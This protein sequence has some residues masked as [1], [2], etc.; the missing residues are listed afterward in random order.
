MSAHLGRYELGEKIAEGGMA[1]VYRA[2]QHGPSGF[3]RACA[4]KVLL[5]ESAEEPE[6]VKLLL[7]E[8]RIAAQLSHPNIC[9]ILELG[10]HGR[11]YFI[12]MEYLEGDSLALVFKRGLA[13][14][15]PL[16]PALAGL[17]VRD[18]AKALTHAHEKCDAQGGALGIIHRDVSPQNVLLTRDGHVKLLD[19]G[20]ARAANRIAKTNGMLLGKCAYMSPEQIRGEPLSPASDL[21]ALSVVLYELLSHRP[22]FAG[23][24]D[25][26]SMRAVLEQ[27]VEP[28][29]EEGARGE[30][31][32]VALAGLERDCR[33][34]IGTAREYARRLDEVL[35]AHPATEVDLAA[36][37]RALFPD[38]ERATVGSRQLAPRPLR[39]RRTRALVA[40][41]KGS[42]RRPALAAAA[43]VV[44][45]GG[46]AAWRWRAP[47]SPPPPPLVVAKAAPEQAS[48]PPT[49]EP[50]PRVVSPIL[51]AP[52]P[53]PREL[54][55]TLAAERPRRRGARPPLA[56]PPPTA[57]PGRLTLDTSPWTEVRLGDRKLGLTPL[58]EVEV[59]AGHQRLRVVNREAHLDK[60]VDADITSDRTTSL[61]IHW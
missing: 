48:V 43:L 55:S 36:E 20:I 41:R 56:S 13:L 34:R 37:V 49:P 53:A 1:E 11:R 21:F 60:M 50:E 40:T 12:A 10:Q 54:R 29:R 33:R 45:L 4:V 25:P 8:A 30:L 7:D 14:R 3:E 27:P 52:V 19:F 17:V 61:R 57:A 28:I 6:L 24:T 31:G 5:P 9:Q 51:P 32:L 47:A 58:V 46:V 42:R 15:R 26:A 22:L 2:I 39:P 35:S 16:P 59:P 44:A 23:K 18:L 38:D